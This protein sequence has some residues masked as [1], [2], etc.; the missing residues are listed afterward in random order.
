LALGTWGAAMLAATVASAASPDAAGVAPLAVVDFS[1]SG[2]PAEAARSF[3]QTHVVNWVRRWGQP[4]DEPEA[5]AQRIG[6]EG[7]SSLRACAAEPATCSGIREN[8]YGAVLSGEIQVTKEAWTVTLT[9]TGVHD[10]TRWVVEA[11]S[12]LTEQQLI[13][14]LIEAAKRVATV[15]A[16]RTARTLSFEPAT[17]PY[18]IAPLIVG[19]VATV[20]GSVFL[21]LAASESS[22]LGEKSTP[23]P[24]AVAARSNGKTYQAVGYSLVAVGVVSLVVGIVL[25]KPGGLPPEPTIAV[26]ADPSRGLLVVGGKFP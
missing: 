5:V 4:V 15:A 18:S 23:L 9:V 3:L 16:T 2:S 26:S 14:P 22:T 17:R 12:Q 6:A 11:V 21:V 10:G 25:F 24:A 13:D 19:G 1:A 8:R 20:T 7:L